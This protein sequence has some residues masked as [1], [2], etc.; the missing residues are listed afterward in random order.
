MPSFT[1]QPLERGPVFWEHEGNRAVRDGRWKLVAK[2]S[3]G[4]MPP[5][6]ELYDIEQDR[7]EQKNLI[8]ENKE[9]AEEMIAQWNK[10]AKRTEVFPSPW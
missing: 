7:T 10:Y 6:W 9:R 5:N 2:R 4:E 3:S 1:N 8:D